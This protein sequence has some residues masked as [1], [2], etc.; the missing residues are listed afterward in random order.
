MEKMVNKTKRR[1]TF[2]ALLGAVVISLSACSL[3]NNDDGPGYSYRPIGSSAKGG[4]S[5][6]STP[7]AGDLDPIAPSSTYSDYI[8]NNIYNLS[9]TPSKGKAKLLVIPVWFNDSTT[10]IHASKRDDVRSDI[11]A[12]YFGKNTDTG[13]RSVKT[14]YEEESNNTLKLDGTIS[15][16]Y[17]CGSSYSY[18]KI[19]NSRD[20]TTSL[21]KNATNWY[22][23][24]F[25]T[26]DK[27]TDYDCDKDGILD[28]VMLIYGAPA[29]KGSAG[30]DE[31]CDNLWAYCYWTQEQSAKNIVKPGVNAFFWASYE[32]MYSKE[33]A[34]TRTGTNHGSGDTSN[35]VTIDAHT[36]IHEMGH[37]FG[38]EDY[39]D[40]SDFKYSPAGGFSMQDRNIGG[41]DPFSSYSLGWSKAYIPTS[42]M[43][44]DLKPFTSSGEII[45]LSPSWNE[46]NSPFDEY[47]ILEYYTND[48]LNYFDS[49]HPYMGDASNFPTG[50]Q[51][52]GIRLW[53]I[54]ARLL[55]ASPGS[56]SFS[57]SRMTT[58]PKINNYRVTTLCT[59]TYDDGRVSDDYL[60]KL[61]EERYYKMNLLELIRNNTT[62]YS[63]S[64]TNKNMTSESLFKVGDSFAM[65]RY[66]RQFQNGDKFNNGKSLGFTFQVN[67]LNSGYASITVTKS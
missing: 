51:E 35:G 50:S 13:W 2:F 56:A 11:Q 67:A 29:L 65:G 12:A 22:F 38:L 25:N 43:N 17:E 63:P 18:Y 5:D 49:A 4:A 3:F 36:Y 7:P 58:N 46:Y 66:K 20:K 8:K 48:G 64:T 27:R 9:S 44:I 52:P 1:L 32:F 60:A 45:V 55:Y 28:G 40:Y 10:F 15:D 47:L 14:Y 37:M 26:S 31:D 57:A 21:V 34:K 23:D 61:D 6:V 24:T 59:N 16:W 33:R 30:H 41:H 53:H 42:T 54:D 39:Y 19:D 62:M